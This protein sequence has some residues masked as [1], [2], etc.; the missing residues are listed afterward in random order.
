[1]E[2]GAFL[3][4]TLQM[5]TRAGLRSRSSKQLTAA[6]V[7]CVLTDPFYTRPL[8]P[9]SPRWNSSSSNGSSQDWL[10]AGNDVGPVALDC[11][12]GMRLQYR[13]IMGSIASTL[14]T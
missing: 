11:N 3:R 6:A 4:A 7:R 9:L 8:T 10:G 2:D 13:Q 5:M 12:V 14:T 1:M